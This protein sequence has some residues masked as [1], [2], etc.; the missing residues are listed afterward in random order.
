MTRLSQA[1]QTSEKMADHVIDALASMV[2]LVT[3]KSK[4]HQTVH[5]SS[6]N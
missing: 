4:S 6:D 1:M 2:S 3:Y 5:N